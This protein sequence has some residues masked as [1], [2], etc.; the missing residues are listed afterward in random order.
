MLKK[1][2]NFE[3]L[4][5]LKSLRDWQKQ[6][7]ALLDSPAA[8]D[9]MLQIFLAYENNE[10]LY[11]KH[12]FISS[13]SYTAIRQHYKI[14]LAS[15]LIY[16]EG[17]VNDRRIKYIRPTPKFLALICEYSN[18]DGGFTQS[19]L[20]CLPPNKPGEP[21]TRIGPLRRL[22]LSIGSEP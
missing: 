17:D 20:N 14:F 18:Q 21:K 19:P 22:N 16:L 11:V 5:K 9:L 13:H 15:D 6:H 8:H 3:F 1:N 2:I 10:P 4:Y 7:F 12:L